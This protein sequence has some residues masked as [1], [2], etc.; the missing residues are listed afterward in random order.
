MQKVVYDALMKRNEE[1]KQFV[2][3]GMADAE[4]AKKRLT[5]AVKDVSALAAEREEQI[6]IADEAYKKSVELAKELKVANQ[7][8]V[9]LDKQLKAQQK[10][11]QDCWNEINRLRDLLQDAITI[12]EQ[13]D[14]AEWTSEERKMMKRVL[15]EKAT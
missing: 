1:R 3:S 12:I 7:E 2:A 10:M 8:N 13:V 14:P 15:R 5:E 11:N 4:M 6:Q 9:K